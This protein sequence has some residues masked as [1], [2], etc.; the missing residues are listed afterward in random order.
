[1]GLPGNVNTITVTGSYY[2][3]QGNPLAGS[4][5]F[6]ASAGPLADPGAPAF[7]SP[8]TVTATLVNGK[9]ST[10]L[11]CTDNATLSPN[12]FVYTV[13]ETL[14][15]TSRSYMISLPHSLGSSVDLATVAPV[16]TLPTV[17]PYGVLALNNTWTGTNT[18]SSPVVLGTTTIATPPGTTTV[19]LRGDG[20][21]QVA[22]VQIAGDLGGSTGN[23]QVVSTHLSAPLPLAQGGTNAASASAAR[24]QL[25]VAYDTTPADYQPD[26]VAGAGANGLV[27]DSGHIHPLQAH[28]FNVKAYGAK[29]DGKIVHDGAMTASSAT[30]ACTTSTPF[31]AG[32]VGKSIIV[33][34]AGPT[35]VT[36]L[37]TTISGFTDSGHVTLAASASTTVSATIVAWAT[38]DTAAFKQAVNAATTFAQA[39]PAGYA[40]VV[41]VPGIYGIFGALVTGGSTLGNA[42]IP[43]PIVATTVNKVTLVVKCLESATA[44]TGAHWQQ[45][46]FQSTAMTLLSGGVFASSGAQGSSVTA[47]GNPAI[48]GGPTQPNHY[49]DSNLVYSNMNAVLQN[50]TLV[51]PLS[52]SGWNYCGAD[53]SGLSQATIRDVNVTV[54]G[55]YVAN[56]FNSPANLASGLSKGILMPA[57]G[58]NDICD[59]Q[60]L[61]VWGGYTWALFATEHTVIRNARLLYC[62]SALTAVGNYFNSV[63]AGHAI[64]GDQISVEGCIYNIYIL[65][66]GASGIGPYLDIAQMDTES[67][68]PRLRDDNSGAL[69]TAQGTVKLT[70]LYTA[71]SI[72][73][74]AATTLQI[75]NGQQ[76]PGVVTAPTYTLGTAFQNTFWRPA[77]VILAG[78]TVTFV[79]IGATMGGPSAPTMNTVWTGALSGTLTVSLPPGGWLEIDGSVKPT[80]NTWILS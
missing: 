18:F 4:V 32:D 3:F 76:P 47:A 79:K 52:A 63:S 10:V 80:T 35:G 78:G 48:I 44:A 64:Y 37:V 6:I 74:D 50:V 17:S 60:N 41:G 9:F 33:R 2:D 43:L 8:V 40:E 15:G 68:A 45:T 23:P 27:A 51:T 71:S 19:F 73:T 34:G 31:T 1:V 53:F 28:Q 57:N 30:L 42:Q 7:L 12:G 20:T 36:T 75:I 59:I 16:T 22:G 5:T 25:G 58:N 29:G 26:G 69:A 54:T 62:W 66:Q 55:T 49:G 77:T 61:S 39:S 38:D 46:Q 56:D 67:P 13:I 11:P 21:W 70:G 65:G 72:Q 24:T 14:P